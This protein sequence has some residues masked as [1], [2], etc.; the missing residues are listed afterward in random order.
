MGRE[1]TPGAQKNLVVI[2]KIRTMSLGLRF[3]LH[4]HQPSF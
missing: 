1:R 4:H 2:L 3:L